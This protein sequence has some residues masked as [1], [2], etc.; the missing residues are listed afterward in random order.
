M[1][2]FSLLKHKTLLNKFNKNFVQFNKYTLQAFKVQSDEE[3]KKLCWKC[4]EET[5]KQNKKDIKSI[6]LEDI[7][8]V[9][10]KIRKKFPKILRRVTLNQFIKCQQSMSLAGDVSNIIY[11]ISHLTPVPLIYL[12]VKKAIGK[13]V[14]YVFK[15]YILTWIAQEIYKEGR[16]VK[17]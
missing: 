16:G 4:I 11:F 8:R 1:A 3:F 14:E 12:G 7:Y 17:K 10:Y 5:A 13:K 15:M 9:L 2:L 6:S